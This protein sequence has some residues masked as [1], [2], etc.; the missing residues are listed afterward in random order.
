MT[1]RPETAFARIDVGATQ[2]LEE[3]STLDP[4]WSGPVT[5]EAAT[6]TWGRN[7]PTRLLAAVLDGSGARGF[8]SSTD[9]DVMGEGMAAGVAGV[10]G[11]RD[12]DGVLEL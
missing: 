8:A 11:D 3:C 12:A 10:A 5:V 9:A 2:D 6:V 4:Q 1:D 7:G